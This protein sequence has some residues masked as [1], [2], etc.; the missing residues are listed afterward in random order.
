M[1]VRSLS[2]ILVSITV[3]LGTLT[4]APTSLATSND[5]V[6]AQHKGVWTTW[7]KQP[8]GGL[9]PL[10]RWKNDKIA[11][12]NPKRRC[13]EVSK[14]IQRLSDNGIFNYFSGD[15][16]NSEPVLCGVRRPG[17]TCN[18][19]NVILTLPRGSDPN[20]A[21]EQL[22]DVA[23]RARGSVLELSGNG[24]D[25]LATYVNGQSYINMEVF[26]KVLEEAEPSVSL[27]QLTPVQ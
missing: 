11:G 17:E 12:W 5:Y 26:K 22:I 19:R 7:V 2:P 8:T 6:C 3:T 10:V 14:R 9:S 20:E 18:S 16:V 25:A 23:G 1:K 24:K 21:V 15:I 13:V 4:I 27:S